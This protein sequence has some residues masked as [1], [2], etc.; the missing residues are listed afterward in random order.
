MTSDQRDMMQGHVA[1]R[2]LA[3]IRDADIVFAWIDDLSCY[4]TL[5]EIGI[6]WSARK[7]VFLGFDNAFDSE[8]FWFA[9]Q[10]AN[11]Y[12]GSVSPA[13]SL[14]TAI[15][16]Y[17]DYLRAMPYDDYLQMPIW[18]RRRQVALDA[19]GGRCQACNIA[20]NLHVHHRTYDR[21]GS[22]LPSDL[23]VFCASCHAKFH[24]KPAPSK[25]HVNGQRVA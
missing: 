5:V 13:T 20:T 18:K 14:R 17:N 22:E 1:R 19:A 3:G 7:Y 16:A 8:D 11:D 21:F 12:C 9:Q 25:I 2:C 6:A 15:R 24:N 23:T 10:L 4:G